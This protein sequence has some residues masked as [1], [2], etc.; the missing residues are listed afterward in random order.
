V[1]ILDTDCLAFGPLRHLRQALSRATFRGAFGKDPDP[2]PYSFRP[3]T[4]RHRFGI[5]IRP[6]LNIGFCAVARDQVDLELV[7][8]WLSTPAYPMA[9]YFAAQTIMAKL[10]SLGDVELL[11]ETECDVGRLRDERSSSVVHYCGPD[12][13]RTRLAMRK[14]GQRMVLDQL[15]AWGSKA[16]TQLREGVRD[17]T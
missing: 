7:E 12:L 17:V 3:E 15:V 4:I 13:G 14:I 9:S 11:P 6:H 1:I 16:S 2:Y 8:R 5:T 10:A